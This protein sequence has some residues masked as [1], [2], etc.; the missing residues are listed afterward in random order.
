LRA[1]VGELISESPLLGVFT[2]YAST[3]VNYALALAYII[4]LTRFIPLTQYGYYNAML[5]L[6]STVGLFFPTFGIDNAIAREGAMNHA[7][8]G[9][10]YMHYS[11]MFALSLTLT[12]AYSVTG[13]ALIPVFIRDGVPAWL[14][15]IVAVWAV[16]TLIQGVNN[17]LNF[18]LWAVGSVATQGVGLTLGNIAFRVIEIA[19]IV[20][21]RNVYAIAVSYLIGQ[22]TI[23]AYYMGKVRQWPSLRAGYG[24]IRA[25]VKEYVNMGFQYWLADY[26]VNISSTLMAYL[27]FKL[28]GPSASGIYG[29]TL[30][31]IGLLSGFAGS[32]GAVFGT[33]ASHGYAVSLDVGSLAKDYSGGYVVVGSILA[34]TAILLTPLAPI[35]HIINGA[36]TAAVPY[37]MLLFAT[38]PASVVD[39]VYMM[40]YW[41]TGRGWLAV[42]RSAVGAVASVLTFIALAHLMNL[43]AVVVANYVGVTLT[44]I[45]YWLNNRPWGWRLGAVTALSLA[46]PMASAMLYAMSDP[47][48]TWPIPQLAVLLLFTLVMLLV[49]PIPRRLITDAP[50][51]LR[52]ILT[53][54]SR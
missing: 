43:Y 48:L 49:K 21:L 54:F 51:R 35:L 17:A 32:V 52:V 41:V 33:V 5:A 28:L 15:G 10:V 24:L 47:A 50:R 26:L 44:L 13:L 7:R 31:I 29:L 45:L 27:V 20:V 30:S 2:N 42:E 1:L 34:L 6:L 8:G 12:L 39:G 3:V 36:Y 11:A 25:R 4:L 19:L 38:T 18:H 9:T 23:A 46:A 22:L 14:M 40:Y 16:Y 53:P 37:V